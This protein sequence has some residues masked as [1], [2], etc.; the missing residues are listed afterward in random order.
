[1]RSIRLR[2]ALP[3]IG[4][5]FLA[6]CGT[7]TSSVPVPNPCGALTL[8]TYTAAQQSKVADEM[9]AAPATAEWP[10]FVRDYGA[11]RSEV[12]ACQSVRS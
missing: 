9:D 3:W 4:L 7:E 1:M 11:L 8:Q 2:R 6:G 5:A 10:A 12:R